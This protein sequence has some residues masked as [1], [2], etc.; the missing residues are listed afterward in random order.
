MSADD[1]FCAALQQLFQGPDAPPSPAASP[2]PAAAEPPPSGAAELSSS[3]GGGGGGGGAGR[4]ATVFAVS[5]AVYEK[6]G[7]VRSM[8]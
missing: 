7:A 2:R 4:K 8:W 1:E 5:E 6:V 3:G